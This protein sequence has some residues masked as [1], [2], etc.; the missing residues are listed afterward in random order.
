[1]RQDPG[2]GAMITANAAAPRVAALTLDSIA[3]AVVV[4][5]ISGTV[6]YWNP[7]AEALFG[8]RAAEAAGKKLPD[9]IFPAGAGKKYNEMLLAPAEGRDWSGKVTLLRKDGSPFPVLAARSIIQEMDGTI[10]GVVGIHADL[11]MHQGVAVGSSHVAQDI[12]PDWETERALRASAAHARAVVEAVHVG[13][14]EIDL[15][16]VARSANSHLLT[17][18]GVPRDQL[19]DR[20]FAEVLKLEGEIARATL[21]RP[22]LGI[23]HSYDIYR[24]RPDGTVLPLRIIL[25]SLL[26]E[27]GV[28]A[29]SVLLATDLT[30]R[31]RIEADLARLALRDGLTG[32][33]NRAALRGRLTRA[34]ARRRRQADLGVLFVDLDHFKVVNDLH[35]HAAGDELLRI[36]ADR[37]RGAVRPEDTVGRVGGDEF[38]VV[39]EELSEPSEAIRIAERLQEALSGPALLGTVEISVMASVGIA[40][41]RRGENIDANEALHRADQ[42]M[43]AAKADSRG[44]WQVFRPTRADSGEQPVIE[45]RRALARDELA[46]HYQPRIDLTSGE[47]VGVEAL[48][49]W[50]HPRRGLLSAPAF[51]PA[52][53]RAGLLPEI[54]MHV[55]SVACTEAAAWNITVSVNVWARQLRTPRLASTLSRTLKDSGL[56]AGRLIVEIPETA[57]MSAPERALRTLTS[58]RSLGVRL[59]VDNFGTGYSSLAHLAR[60]PLDALKVDRQFVSGLGVDRERAAVVAAA[61]GLA[62]ATGL[63]VVAEGVETGEQQSALIALGCEQAQGY[64]FGPPMPPEEIPQLLA[65]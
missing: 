40:V 25:S 31:K 21:T 34:L 61:V 26:D 45:L 18:L 59:A 58:L 54:G 63:R 36:L 64:L 41:V 24:R 7:A 14:G 4:T 23:E 13:I 30:E 32:L 60:F 56:Q 11:S 53:D 35:G 20:P 10:I 48:A 55:V 28:V 57:V 8:Y 27:K 15:T 3:H 62:H 42:A 38:V 65:R 29:G 17:L 37:L 22:A 6:T 39:C 33:L 9:L 1:M 44:S 51:L 43:Y 47:I 16:G 5:D 49:R 50:R 52:A 12:T 2:G 46:V 19:I